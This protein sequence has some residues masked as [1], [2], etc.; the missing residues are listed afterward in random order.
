V[1][2]LFVSDLHLDASAPA[3]VQRF[4][5]FLALEARAAASLYILGDLFETWIGDDDPDPVRSQV[6]DALR[7]LTASG[8]PVYLMCGNRDFLYGEAFERR[9]GVRLLAD[10]TVATLDGQRIL[11]THGDLLCTDDVSYQELRSTVRSLAFKD[12]VSALSV[13]ARQWMA[14]AARAG[15]RAHVRQTAA[16]IMDVNSKAVIAAFEATSTLTMIHGHTHRPAEHHHS[17]TNGVARRIVLAAWDE[18]GEFLVVS[19]KN[20]SRQRVN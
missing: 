10:P 12:R 3:T 16:D 1:R 6:C 13:E 8:V 14:S 5:G 15:S 2:H 4:L 9:T 19:D 20:W 17:T 18:D 11:L 7:T